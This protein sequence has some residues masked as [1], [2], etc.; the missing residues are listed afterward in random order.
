MEATLALAIIFEDKPLAN[1]VGE[2][3][4]V[5][6]KPVDIE[7]VSTEYHKA[8]EILEFHDEPD[9]ARKETDLIWIVAH[10]TINVMTDTE[11]LLDHAEPYLRAGA[12]TVFAAAYFA[13]YDGS[14]EDDELGDGDDDPSNKVF[15]Y[16]ILLQNGKAQIT[17]FT[18]KRNDMPDDLI[19]SLRFLLIN[20]KEI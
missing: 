10:D 12:R 11:M 6:T 2:C 14:D 4:C 15:L 19:E 1:F 8:Y 3:L 17:S 20:Q 5:D 13:D 16:K 7:D 18:N 9:S